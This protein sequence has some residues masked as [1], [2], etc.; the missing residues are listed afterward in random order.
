M[1]WVLDTSV[2]IGS[3]ETGASRHLPATMAVSKLLGRNEF[4]CV[5]PQN[6][7]EFW[8][9]ATRPQDANGLGF[10]IKETQSAIDKIKLQFALKSEDE[11]IF[12]NWERLVTTYSVSGKTTH[13]ARI[14][15][16]MQTH[17]IENLLTFNVSDFKRYPE[18]INVFAPE[19]VI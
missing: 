9:V 2:L 14:V 7:V 5:F 13:D 3:I 16:A 6:L 8:T 15:A 19:D 11:T 10:S 12:E 17:K 18:I 1:S 4:V